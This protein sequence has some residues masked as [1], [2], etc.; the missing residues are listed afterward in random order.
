MLW[1]VGDFR[2]LK[3]KSI[4]IHKT[5]FYKGLQLYNLLATNIKSELNE[6]IFRR[7]L[8]NLISFTYM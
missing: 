2:I 6:N 3:V 1:N 8:I 5:L 7:K 4:Q